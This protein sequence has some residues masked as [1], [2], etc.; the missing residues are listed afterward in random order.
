AL[1]YASQV[2]HNTRFRQGSM[3]F[4]P[5]EDTHALSRIAPQRYIDIFRGV[6]K[7]RATTTIDGRS[8]L[9]DTYHAEWPYG[10]ERLVLDQHGPAYTPEEIEALPADD[11]E[12]SACGVTMAWSLDGQTFTELPIDNFRAASRRSSMGN[13]RSII[14]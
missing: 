3:Q 4:A 10:F 7:V 11:S 1:E 9:V 5:S 13:R 8:H 12:V 6:Q 14:A 2:A